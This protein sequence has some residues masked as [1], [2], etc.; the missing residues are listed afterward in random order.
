MKQA[1]FFWLLP[2]CSA[3]WAFIVEVKEIVC[4]CLEV[5]TCTY[6]HVL[7]TSGSY[8]PNHIRFKEYVVCRLPMKP[9]CLCTIL[10]TIYLISCLRLP[11]IAFLHISHTCLLFQSPN[12][13]LLVLSIL[14]IL[15]YLFPLQL[16]IVSSYS[17]FLLQFYLNVLQLYFCYPI[18]PH[19]VHLRVECRCTC[20]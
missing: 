9:D 14:S 1:L 15:I 8:T 12:S 4:A 17:L 20:S 16:K 2:I 5:Y 3:V 10:S 13:R 7:G 19:V 6:I 11:H 18:L